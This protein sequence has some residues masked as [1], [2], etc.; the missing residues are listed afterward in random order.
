MVNDPIDDAALGLLEEH[1][2]NALAYRPTSV[3]ANDKLAL[4]HEVRRLQ[5]FVQWIA[6]HSTDPAAVRE[7]VAYGAKK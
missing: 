5:R 4:V 6:D 3:E 7:A 2:V 1:A